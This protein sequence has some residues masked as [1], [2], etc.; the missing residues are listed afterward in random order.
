MIVAGF[1]TSVMLGM[2]SIGGAIWGL[3]LLTRRRRLANTPD[4]I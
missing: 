2:V 4:P 3:V 1:V